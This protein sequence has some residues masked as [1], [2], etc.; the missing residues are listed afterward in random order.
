M[1]KSISLLLTF[2]ILTTLIPQAFAA[3]GIDSFDPEEALNEQSV[4]N[5]ITEFG[6]LAVEGQRFYT[7]TGGDG[8]AA[9]V[10]LS[11]RYYYDPDTDGLA[12]VSEQSTDD[13]YYL[14]Y[15][16]CFSSP[17][18]GSYVC[19]LYTGEDEATIDELDVDSL[20]AAWNNNIGCFDLSDARLKYS[21]ERDGQYVFCYDVNGTELTLYFDADSGWLHYSTEEVWEEGL[22]V[23][24][25]LVYSECNDSLP[26]RSYRDFF[27]PSAGNSGTSAGKTADGKLSF[28]TKDVYGNDI[29]SS[30]LTGK[31]LVL[32]NFWEPWCGWCLEEMPDM[33]KLYQKYKD[34]GLLFIGV[35]KR[36][37]DV[38]DEEA[39]EE[40]QNMGIT[41][42]IIQDCAE[43]QQFDSNGWP[44]T[45]VF[46][47]N[48]NQIGDMIDG[49]KPEDAWESLIIQNLL[50]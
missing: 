22:S 1:K 32:V 45:F 46:D 17:F 26:S 23:F 41:Y 13:Y 15:A 50:R 35:Y 25:T 11:F 10:D 31:K 3:G 29:D 18:Q 47:G 4:W 6:S 39:M 36:D 20:V 37:E 40:I 28:H 21:E 24:T 48:G 16:E 33:Q 43:L 12:Y 7:S 2:L 30:I 5:Y 42:P 34:Q 9:A 44:F 27:G 14:D 19:D 8:D 49:Y 38:T